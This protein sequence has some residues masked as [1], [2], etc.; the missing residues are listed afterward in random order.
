MYT[1]NAILLFCFLMA[2]IER[3]LEVMA[4]AVTPNDRGLSFYFLGRSLK[5]W[6]FRPKI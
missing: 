6:V 2:A 5:G 1:G 4:N 3:F